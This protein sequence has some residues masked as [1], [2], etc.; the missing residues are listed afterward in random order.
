VTAGAVYNI[1]VFMPLLAT[2]V[3]HVDGGGYGII[4]AAFGVGALPGTI[5]AAT[6]GPVPS[7]RQVRSLGIAMGISVGICAYAPTYWLL[8]VTVALVG[9]LSMWFI[10]RANA[11]VML[12]S[13][14]ALRGRVMGVWTMALPG[15]NVVTGLIVGTAAES[16]GPRIAYAGVGV[17]AVCAT[18]I[19]WRTLDR[20]AG[21]VEV[22]ASPVP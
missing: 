15:M 8:L 1:S 6:S 12:D 7:G 22:P 13:D 21:Y 11:F 17:A 4:A 19:G 14:P 5:L 9:A 16:W 3:F 10:A 20:D 2:E 18:L